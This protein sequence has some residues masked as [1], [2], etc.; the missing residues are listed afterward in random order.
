MYMMCE[1]KVGVRCKKSDKDKVEAAAKK[2]GEEFKKEMKYDCQA[3]VD[4]KNYLPDES[5]V[6][7]LI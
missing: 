3:V 1:K 6:A 4:E 7:H 2:A 5:Y